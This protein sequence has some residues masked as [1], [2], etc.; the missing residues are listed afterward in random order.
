VSLAVAKKNLENLFHHHLVKSRRQQRIKFY[1][2]LSNPD[3]QD[4]ISE[5][6]YVA[7]R[8]K[9]EPEMTTIERPTKL[10]RVPISELIKYVEETNLQA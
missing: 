8:S 3:D 7:E 1:L 10:L 9:V 2:N 4:S 5:L 6:T